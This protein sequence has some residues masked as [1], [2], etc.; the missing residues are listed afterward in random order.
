MKL[1]EALNRRLAEAELYEQFHLVLFHDNVY[2]N[3]GELLAHISQRSIL[4][5]VVA[6][7]LIEN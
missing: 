5:N 2:S 6:Q 1:I 4:L 3:K 7:Y